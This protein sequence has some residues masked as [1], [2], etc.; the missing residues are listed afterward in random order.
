MASLNPFLLIIVGAAVTFVSWMNPDMRPKF[1]LFFWI[2]IIMILWGVGNLAIGAI[3]KKNEK[4]KTAPQQQRPQHPRQQQARQNQQQQASQQ[5]TWHHDKNDN[6]PNHQV[7][8]QQQHF[9]PNCGKQKS[10]HHRF[11][12]SCGYGV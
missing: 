12:P 9:C 1:V 10:P 7:T 8:H 5:Q 6:F 4:K 2:G 11:C 3:A